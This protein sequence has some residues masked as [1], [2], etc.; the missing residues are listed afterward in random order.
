VNAGAQSPPPPPRGSL[1]D[2]GD[3]SRASGAGAPEEGGEESAGFDE[4]LAGL[5]GTISRLADGT[6]PLEELVAA[7]QRAVG[8]LSEAQARLEILKARA[9]RLVI[10]LKE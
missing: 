4:V 7:H 6:A 10:A 9:D 5:E 8:L 1:R 2:P 3:T